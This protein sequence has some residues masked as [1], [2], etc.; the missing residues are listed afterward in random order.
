MDEIEGPAE[1]PPI[2]AEE[3]RTQRD[4][5]VNMALIS[6]MQELVATGTVDRT[7]LIARLTQSV[8]DLDKLG[9]RTAGSSIEQIIKFLG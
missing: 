6:L 7:S 5:A 3:F 8:V 4:V 9:H 2:S 1:P